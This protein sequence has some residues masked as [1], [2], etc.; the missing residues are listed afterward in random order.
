[1]PNTTREKYGRRLGATLCTVAQCPHQLGTSPYRYCAEHL[2]AE[3]KRPAKRN[4]NAIQAERTDRRV[5]SFIKRRR[6][7]VAAHEVREFLRA[8]KSSSNNCLARLF[9]AHKIAKHSVGYYVAI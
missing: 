8:P 4:A 1:M 6:R 3:A 7:P 5:L 9:F 2:P